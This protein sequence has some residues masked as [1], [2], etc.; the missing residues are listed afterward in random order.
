[1]SR[2][3][4]SAGVRRV[5]RRGSVRSDRSNAFEVE[6]VGLNVDLLS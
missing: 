4:P 3:D 1:M 5:Q 2:T 6:G